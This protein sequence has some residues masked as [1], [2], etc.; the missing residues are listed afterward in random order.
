[1]KT[2]IDSEF[3]LHTTNPYG[4]FREV[5]TGFFDENACA[6]FIEGHLHVPKGESFTNPEGIVFQ[7]KMTAPWRNY[8]ELDAAQ[9]RYERQLIAEYR[10]ALT[11]S[12]PVADLAAA[13]QEGVNSAY[14]Q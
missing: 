11:D 3:H 5:R 6:E 12:I 9:R 2:F 1:M 10:A 7:G 14:D 8:N 4:V 13:Y